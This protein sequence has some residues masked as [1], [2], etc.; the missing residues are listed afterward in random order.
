M[1]NENSIVLISNKWNKF[2]SNLTVFCSY[3]KI[4]KVLQY[5]S[6]PSLVHNALFL[7][8][9]ACLIIKLNEARLKWDTSSILSQKPSKATMLLCCDQ[10]TD[11][12]RRVQMTKWDKKTQ[13]NRLHSPKS[14]EVA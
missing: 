11:T 8:S 7:L 2:L 13:M 14:V 3:Q 6:Y 5:P 4:Y 9:L 12:E 1:K 10:N